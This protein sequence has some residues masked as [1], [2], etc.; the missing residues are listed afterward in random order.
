MSTPIQIKVNLDRDVAAALHRLGCDDI[1]PL[2]RDIWFAE[3]LSPG[4]PRA[5]ALLSGHIVIR[6]RSG[7]ADDVTVEL[8]PC[9]RARL[10][11]RWAAP[12][13]DPALHYRIEEEWCA[14]RRMLSASAISRRPPGSLRK[15]VAAGGDITA[16]LDSAQRQFLVNC[17][18]PGVAVDH[19]RALGPV[20][21][22]RWVGVAVGEVHADIER[23]TVAGLDLL[24]FSLRITPRPDGPTTDPERGALDTQRALHN[25]LRALGLAP[26]T[27]RTKTERVLIALTE[28]HS[29]DT[30]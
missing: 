23:W 2:R 17:T 4:S 27:G 5:P 12:F 18:P 16:V 24:E 20:A 6:L 10:V 28:T 19:L 11:G 13:T 3:P 8:R 26:A 14:G 21:A 30:E 1:A 7:T 15:A 25:A 29:G 9:E 22:A